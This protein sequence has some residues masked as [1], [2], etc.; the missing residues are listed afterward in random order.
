MAKE[1]KA[2]SETFEDTY[3][4]LEAIVA[5]LEQGGLSLDEAI[6]LYEQGM[7]LARTCQ[8][9]L[10]NAEQR[11]TKVRESFAQA[12]GALADQ[13]EGYDYVAEEERSLEPG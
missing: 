8:E 2:S 4:R 5:R 1:T 7:I 6:D 11:I 9:R 12:R 10:D 3:A 13:A